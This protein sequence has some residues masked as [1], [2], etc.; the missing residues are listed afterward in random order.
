MS[1]GIPGTICYFDDISVTGNN[2][3]DHFKNLFRS[4][5]ALMQD[6]AQYLRHRIDAQGVH[7]TPDKIAAIQKEPTLR[8]IAQLRSFL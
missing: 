3:E 2:D 1:Q 7:T 6:S 5:C 8:N 4:K